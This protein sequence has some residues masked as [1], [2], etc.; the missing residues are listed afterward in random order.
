M[1]LKLVFAKNMIF[2][3]YEEIPIYYFRLGWFNS[4]FCGGDLM[5]IVFLAVS[6]VNTYLTPL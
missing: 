5:L 3:V 1:S 4:Q 6:E 2:I